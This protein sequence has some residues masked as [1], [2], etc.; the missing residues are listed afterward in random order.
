MKNYLIRG[1]SE[2]V[3]IRIFVTETT[4]IAEYARNIHETSP[5][6]TVALGKFLTITALMGNNLK[7]DKDKLTLQIKGNG[8]LGELVSVSDSFGNIKAFP[9]NPKAVTNKNHKVNLIQ[10]EDGSTESVMTSEFN[11]SSLVGR[12]GF[13]T[14]IKDMG[15]KEPYIGKIPLAD[16]S[17]TGDL[18]AYYAVSEQTPTYIELDTQLDEEGKVVAAGGYMIQVLPGATD[19]EIEK[20]EKNLSKGMKYSDMLR[21]KMK[22]EEIAEHI[23]NGLPYKL[24]V[25]MELNYKCNC[26]RERMA[27]V[28]VSTGTV[29]IQAIIKEMGEAE[30]HCH[31]CNTRHKFN[32]E[33]LEDLLIISKKVPETQ[34]Q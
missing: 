21:A 3:S 5:A 2:D 18:M 20:L 11:I 9:G 15:M 31:F 23:M 7:S 1:L 24:P 25:K 13:L 4:E 27:S 22:P 29:E 33:E 19:E 30:V 32:K 26:S 17:I 10:K 8:T 34:L 28:L 12:E 14:V 6:V 16:G